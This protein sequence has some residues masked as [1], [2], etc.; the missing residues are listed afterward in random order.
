[1][2]DQHRA[3]LVESQIELHM[4]VITPQV[5]ADFPHINKDVVLANYDAVEL[6]DA[7][8]KGEMIGYYTILKFHTIKQSHVNDLEML[9][10]TSRA[11]NGRDRELLVSQVTRQEFKDRTAAGG[12]MFGMFGKKN[13]AR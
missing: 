12:N 5:V 3:Q 10:A 7:R 9:S 13:E 2:S 8:I 4:E 11:K 6:A 1:M